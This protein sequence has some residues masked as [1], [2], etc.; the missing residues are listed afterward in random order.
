[1]VWHFDF[2][3]NSMRVQEKCG[4]K[5][6]FTSTKVYE[7]LD[8]KEISTLYYSLFNPEYLEEK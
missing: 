8:N 4:F 5:Y 2:N 6:R 7:R 3:L 1:M